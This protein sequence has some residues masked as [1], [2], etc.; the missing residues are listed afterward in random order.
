[1]EEQIDTVSEVERFLREVR[2]GEVEQTGANEMGG[3]A[4][5]DVFKDTKSFYEDL[6]KAIKEDKETQVF[7]A[8]FCREMVLPSGLLI[9]K[10]VNQS[11]RARRLQIIVYDSSAGKKESVSV[12]SELIRLEANGEFFITNMTPDPKTGDIL[13]KT[14]SNPFN[15]TGRLG[16]VE[17]EALKEFKGMISMYLRSY[18]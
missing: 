2:A 6:V 14:Y 10:I 11:L 5:E 9:F 13:T 16:K 3:P 1:M 4:M 15:K 8:D 18:K 17:E 12:S 7:D